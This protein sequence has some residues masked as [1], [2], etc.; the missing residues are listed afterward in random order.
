MQKNYLVEVDD[1]FPLE[2]LFGTSVL[3]IESNSNS[4]WPMLITKAILKFYNHNFKNYLDPKY[5][6]S[7]ESELYNGDVLYSLTGMYTYTID[8]SKSEE[9][10]WKYLRDISSDDNYFSNFF[11]LSS[12]KLRYA[13]ANPIDNLSRIRSD[14][15]IDNDAGMQGQLVKRPITH[16]AQYDFVKKIMEN[17]K[18]PQKDLLSGFLYSVH[19]LFENEGLNMQ[20]VKRISDEEIILRKRYADLLM[21]KTQ[22]MNKEDIIKLK[23]SRRDLRMRIKDL[24]NATREKFNKIPK[25][26][27]MGINSGLFNND[28]LNINSRF[29]SKEIK[30]AKTCIL[31][32]LDAPPNYFNFNELKIEEGSVVSGSMNTSFF[33]NLE[34]ALRE[35]IRSLDDFDEIENAVY[36]KGR[37]ESV[38]IDML[39]FFNNFHIINVHYDPSNF[40]FNEVVKKLENMHIATIDPN[41]E[42]LVVYKHDDANKIKDKSF[43]INFQVDAA[44]SRS[45]LMLQKYDFEKFQSIKS[46]CPVKSTNSSMKVPVTS[47]N[48]VYRLSL[49]SPHRNIIN[50]L[51]KTHFEIMSISKYLKSIESWKEASFK[52]YSSGLL[53][54]TTNIVAKYYIKSSRIQNIVICCDFD[55]YIASHTVFRLFHLKELQVE[56]SI[57][58]EFICKNIDSK[59]I[60]I[61]TY[62]NLEIDQGEYLFVVESSFH[63][64]IKEMNFDLNFLSKYEPEITQLEQY[65]TDEYIERAKLQCDG[66]LTREIIMFKGLSAHISFEFGLKTHSVGFDLVDTKKNTSIKEVD[67][68]GMA[69]LESYHNVFFDFYVNQVKIHT[70]SG[71]KGLKVANLTLNKSAETD[72]ITFHVRVAPS[73]IKELSDESFAKRIYWIIRLRSNQNIALVRDERLQEQDNKM[74]NLWEEKAPGRGEQARKVRKEYLEKLAQHKETNFNSGENFDLN[75]AIE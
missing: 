29:T 44:E 41:K 74:M 50:L 40:K 36:P 12:L 18:R 39:N 30:I 58:C 33:K 70:L 6:I 65:E 60:Y 56:D 52:V 22:F 8:L 32:K 25:F 21:T 48:Q 66:N 55:K 1:Y 43:Y 11:K 14:N 46:F 23:K 49:Y 28:K 53:K 4:I 35:K 73:T 37:L 34:Q 2:P 72:E 42:V 20:N 19:E 10:D 64:N 63:E 7:H 69:D 51:S 61:E 17:D 47:D 3:P 9:F 67:L 27:L 13:K 38:W 75:R 31:N 5:L 24:E 68:S 59:N 57:D 54:D 15:A 71:V 16:K 62:G 45:S 26:K